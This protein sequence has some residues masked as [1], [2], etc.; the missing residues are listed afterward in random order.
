MRFTNIVPVDDI[1]DA[2]GDGVLTINDITAIIDLI[3]GQDSS[4]NS[5]IADINRDHKTNIDDVIAL[6]DI[7]LNN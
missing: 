4:I 6:I 5:I 7:F 2:D 1:G 3:L